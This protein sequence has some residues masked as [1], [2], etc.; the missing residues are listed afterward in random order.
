MSILSLIYAQI[1]KSD[2]PSNQISGRFWPFTLQGEV[3]IAGDAAVA[4]AAGLPTRATI[5]LAASSPGFTDPMAGK[6]VL[7]CW[8]LNQALQSEP[9]INM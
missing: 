7:W 6:P 9:N 5:V 8:T 4:S 2:D 1:A 3:L